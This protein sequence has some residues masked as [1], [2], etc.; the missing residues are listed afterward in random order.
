[1][2]GRG[3]HRAFQNTGCIRS[4]LFEKLTMKEVIFSEYS[5]EPF[6]DE[7][8]MSYKQEGGEKSRIRSLGKILNV[9]IP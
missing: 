1:M 3:K 9:Y 8:T 6:H 2:L 5:Y 7:N 4:T